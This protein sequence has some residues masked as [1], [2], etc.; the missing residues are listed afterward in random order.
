METDTCPHRVHAEL[1]GRH[2]KE[3]YIQTIRLKSCKRRVGYE[4]PRKSRDVP[5]KAALKLTHEGGKVSRR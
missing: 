5:K 1:G 3:S 2:I 4:S